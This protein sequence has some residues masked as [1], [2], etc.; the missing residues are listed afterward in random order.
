[1]G[2]LEY[3]IHICTYRS[4]EY[5]QHRMCFYSVVMLQQKKFLYFEPRSHVQNWIKEWV[6]KFSRSSWA[7]SLF[8][9]NCCTSGALH[10]VRASKIMCAGYAVAYS[11][12]WWALIR[13]VAFPGVH[14]KNSADG[15]AQ[16]TPNVSPTYLST[17][18]QNKPK[19]LGFWGVCSLWTESSCIYYQ[20]IT[21]RQRFSSQKKNIEGYHGKGDLFNVE[22]L[23]ILNFSILLYCTCRSNFDFLLPHQFLFN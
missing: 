16:I 17:Q 19:S 5:V 22:K 18:A 20:T 23:S 11:V 6:W 4:H 14:W 9:S 13:T 8:S 15:L 3:Y 7:P 12:F 10:Y 2:Q 1:M 21:H